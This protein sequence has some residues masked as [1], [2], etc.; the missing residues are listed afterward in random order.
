MDLTIKEFDIES[1]YE[2]N[3]I[4]TETKFTQQ[5]EHELD[6]VLISNNAIANIHVVKNI[7]S[8]SDSPLTLSN[9]NSDNEDRPHDSFGYHKLT[10]NDVEKSLG[11]YYDDTDTKISSELDI[12]ITYLKGQ[13]N[14]YIQSKIV[15]QTKLNILLIPSLMITAGCTIFAPFI[16]QFPW[17]G[18]FIS[19]LNAITTMLI[20]LA[21]YLKL[22][23][24]MQTFYHT[25]NQYDK[26]ET[27]LEFVSSKMLFVGREVDKSHIVLEKIHEIEKKINEIK[28][29]NPLFIPDE[30]RRAFPIICNINIF[31]FIKRMEVYK[32]NLVVKLKDVKNEIR[33]ILHKWNKRTSYQS[34]IDDEFYLETSSEKKSDLRLRQ[35]K[36]IKFLYDI[37][38]KIKEE[39][40]HYKTAYGYID[41]IFTK[42]I[43]YAQEKKN[44]WF[45]F[46][47]NNYN[48]IYSSSGNPVI[49]KY[50]RHIF[51]NI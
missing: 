6:K 39:I 29:W 46:Q 24:S 17:S 48:E 34:D 22:E 49:D 40:I 41:E 19:G 36:R 28:E 47:S 37:K 4:L 45:F 16:Q 12:L 31:S 23:S 2:N 13:K 3:D 8:G 25:A 32:K 44:G 43:K 11:K 7:Y 14:L 30:V 50:L 21:N 33:Y 5:L 35:E 27:S 1:T 51:T 15:S 42:E 9:N 26:L 18:G 10:Y 20:A 38:E